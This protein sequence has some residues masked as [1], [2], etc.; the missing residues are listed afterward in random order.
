[1]IDYHKEIVSALSQVLP[2]HFEMT[3]SSDTQTPCISYMESNNTSS[4]S[5]DTLGYSRINYQIKV[6]ANDIAEIQKYALQVDAVLRPIGFSR[7]SSVEL[8]DNQSTMI[9]KVMN[10]EALAIEN[11]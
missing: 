3:L 11:Y 5:G 8:Y 6:W 9:Q 1:M 2:V 7:T 10:Y 4:M